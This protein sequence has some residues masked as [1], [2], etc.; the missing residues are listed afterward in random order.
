MG[1]LSDRGDNERYYRIWAAMDLLGSR[2]EAYI[3]IFNTCISLFHLGENLRI[4][5][6]N[7]LVMIKARAEIS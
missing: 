5:E 3:C 4:F 6:H 1:T 2:M 7:W